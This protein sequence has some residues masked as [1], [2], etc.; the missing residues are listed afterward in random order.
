M[1]S[2]SVIWDTLAKAIRDNRQVM[3]RHFAPGGRTMTERKIDPYCLVNHKGEW[4][5]LIKARLLSP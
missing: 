2:G 1:A 3:V 5:S 4:Y